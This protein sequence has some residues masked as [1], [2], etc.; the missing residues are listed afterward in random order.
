MRK[1]I[2]GACLALSLEESTLSKLLA[3][4]SWLPER[5]LALEGQEK[6]P[7]LPIPV[8]TQRRL[9]YRTSG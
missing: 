1:R 6:A 9:Q 8:L 3:W 4:G 2:H 7:P 5:W